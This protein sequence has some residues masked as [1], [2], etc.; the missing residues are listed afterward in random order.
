MFSD[1]SD[2]QIPRRLLPPLS[3]VPTF[4]F[5]RPP[6]TPAAATRRYTA[7]THPSSRCSAATRPPP[8]PPPAAAPPPPPHMPCTTVYASVLSTGSS[9]HT[10]R[11][12]AVP[13]YKE[14]KSLPTH[15]TRTWPAPLGPGLG[16]KCRPISSALAVGSPLVFHA[17][18]CCVLGGLGCH[19]THPPPGGRAG[20]CQAPSPA[21]CACCTCASG[22]RP[23]PN[24]MASAPSRSNALAFDFR[25]GLPGTGSR[26]H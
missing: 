18:K 13:G 24:P 26:G 15:G 16:A 20:H 19:S 1:A 9:Q 4:R 21:L 23:P 7:H 25:M 17:A 3:V 11:M 22:G 12:W 2:S 8:A 6:T 5:C 10:T 14:K